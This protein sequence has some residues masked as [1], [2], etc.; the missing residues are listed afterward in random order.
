[1]RCDHNKVVIMF[2]CLF[3]LCRLT[4]IVVATAM[5]IVHRPLFFLTNWDPSIVNNGR[6]NFD[7]VKQNGCHGA[8]HHFTFVLLFGCLIVLAFDT[9]NHTTPI[10]NSNNHDCRVV[11]GKDTRGGA[12]ERDVPRGLSRLFHYHTSQVS[13]LSL[14]NKESSDWTIMMIMNW[15]A[16]IIEKRMLV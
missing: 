7:K 5:R 1:M 14:M 16:N 8:E 11:G 13:L 3:V 12:G 2:V 15:N 9:H 4:G 6:K 10:K